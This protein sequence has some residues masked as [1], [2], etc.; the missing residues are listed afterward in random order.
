MMNDMKSCLKEGLGGDVRVIDWK[1]RRNN[2]G[3]K[4]KMNRR[5]EVM[6]NIKDFEKKTDSSSCT[7]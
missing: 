1:R 5:M 4:Q 2:K 6:E 3:R 7:D